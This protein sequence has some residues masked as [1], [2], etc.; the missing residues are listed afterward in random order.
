MISEED[1]E[2]DV[3]VD[4]DT[5]GINDDALALCHLFALGLVPRL[6]TTVFGNASAVSSA[7]HA[8]TLARAHSLDI[9]VV[10]G[11]ERP[12]WWH[13]P[14]REQVRAV[15]A[16]LPASTYLASLSADNTRFWD[17][18]AEDGPAPDA[19]ATALTRSHGTDVLALG[20]TTNIARALRL[21]DPSVPA[22][23]RLW[24]SGGSLGGGNVTEHAEFNTF[25]DPE[26]LQACLAARWKAV[27]MVPLE[28]MEAPRLL[29]AAVERIRRTG[30]P[31]G[32]AL[33][34]LECESP[35]GENKDREPIWDVVAAALLADASLP[36]KQE[37]GVISVAT[38]LPDR[39][40]IRFRRG[41]GTHHLV[42]AIDPEAVV[43]RFEAAVSRPRRS[44]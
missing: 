40:T 25:A 24:I 43:Q 17:T 3:I 42:T 13:E 7:G 2:R 30:T 14:F 29:P 26:A 32:A 44:P 5:L 12:L 37:T 9:D 1:T 31:L 18:G 6:I 27:V 15:L 11:C 23:H 19:L 28:V 35:R 22:R 36:Y 41:E 21:V 34:K 4:T 20:P 33:D 8:R 38:G 10:R 39:G 16:A